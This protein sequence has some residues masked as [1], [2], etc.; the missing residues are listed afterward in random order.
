MVI[1]VVSHSEVDAFR[2]CPF[3]WQLSYAE[4]WVPPEVSPALAKGSLTHSVLE[5]WYAS[6]IEGRTP[7]SME[8]VWDE[9]ELTHPDGAPLDEVADLVMWMTDRYEKRYG[10]DTEWKVLDVER[11]VQLPIGRGWRI[12]GKID[13]VMLNQ[14]TQK[15]WIWDHKTGVRLPS[16]K[17]L[18]LD[19]Q[20]TLYAWAL[21]NSGVPVTGLVYNALR[22]QRNKG[23]MDL[24]DSFSRTMLVRRP[25]QT[26]A[27]VRD[28]LAS[29]RESRRMLRTSKVED[30]PRHY[31]SERCGWRCSF[32]EACLFG[33]KGGI[34]GTR[35]ML[36]EQGYEHDFTRH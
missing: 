7:I 11:A 34:G 36:I 26:E 2:Q 17:D 33:S 4:R 9:L 29:A 16:A 12:K 28:F 14:R 8:R 32:T 6:R 20:F 31:D 25:E 27:V 13:L 19:I 30:L 5:R 35:G 21:R 23:P 24:D 15:T 18:D 22:T 3:K 1:Q 10:D